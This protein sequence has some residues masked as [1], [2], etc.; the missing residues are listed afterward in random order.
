M[1]EAYYYAALKSEPKFAENNV[2]GLCV[3]F[4]RMVFIGGVADANWQKI[5]LK[6]AEPY[7][8][9]QVCRRYRRK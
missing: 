4:I 1:E 7:R 2:K 8:F 6:C 5:D 9:S 3:V